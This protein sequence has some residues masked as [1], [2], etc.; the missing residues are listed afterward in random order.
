MKVTE[1]ILHDI[2]E[3][4]KINDISYDPVLNRI[5]SI[6][7]D[8]IPFE[9]E[10]ER[11]LVSVGFDAGEAHLGSMFLQS[12]KL[13]HPNKEDFLNK[14]YPII[15]IDSFPKEIQDLYTKSLQNEDL[16]N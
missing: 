16:D 1:K 8:S 7:H 13:K 11:K 5:I 9:R 12:L 10:I 6:I 2:N 4:I 3:M 14:E 15:S